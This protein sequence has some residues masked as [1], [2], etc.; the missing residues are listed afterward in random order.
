MAQKR[1]RTNNRNG[2]GRRYSGTRQNGGDQERAL[3][4]SSIAAETMRTTAVRVAENTM[5][6]ADIMHEQTEQ[7]VVDLCRQSDLMA[8]QVENF[9]GRW[10][11]LVTLP[12]QM[13]R[14]AAAKIEEA[15]EEQW[16]RSS[17]RGSGFIR[18]VERC[19]RTIA[20]GQP[21]IRI[22]QRTWS[23]GMAK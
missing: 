20:L 7:L 9:F 18:R 19:H 17:Q 14:K 15:R 8:R 6:A 1:K 12:T 3:S 10:V 5:A 21:R 13:T 23:D 11:K 4:V 16:P 22:R 2:G